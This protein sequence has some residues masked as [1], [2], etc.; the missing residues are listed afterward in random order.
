MDKA[1]QITTSKGGVQT[2]IVPDSFL[3]GRYFSNIRKFILQQCQI[4]EITLLP[5]DVFEATVGFSVVYLFRKVDKV[6]D[7]HKLLSKIATNVNEFSQNSMKSFAFPQDYFKSRAYNRFVLFFDEH[8]KFLIEKIESNSTELGKFISFSSG[9]ISNSG[10][11]NI[12]SKEK[13][14]KD[15]LPGIISGSEINSYLVAPEGYFIHYRKEVIKSGY[16]N[17][18]YFHEKLFVRQTGDKLI[19][20]YDNKGLLALN[21]VHIGSITNQALSLKYVMAL[22]NSKLLN[23]YYKAISL[24]TGRTMAQIDIETLEKLPLKFGNRTLSE[25]IENL[26]DRIL[27]AKA[28]DAQ[29]DTSAL[30]REIDRLVYGLYGLTEEEIRI[31]EGET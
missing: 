2:F 21:N 10:Q 12:I 14:G 17:I 8:T 6:F 20:A 1:I 22:L 16:G 18:N 4:L 26:V 24:E 27:A 30:E 25:K 3:L 23:F 9:L 11:R 15:W 28:K 13:R 7:T 29:A 19:C 31:V 5:F